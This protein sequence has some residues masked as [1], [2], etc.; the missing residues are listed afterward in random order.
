MPRIERATVVAICGIAF[1]LPLMAH[2]Y[3]GTASRYIGDDYC[4]GYIFRDHGLV[5]GQGWFYLN[6]GAVPTT[7]LLMAIT[8]PAGLWLTPLLPGL[9]LAV[10]VGAG[11]WS[12][13]R[14][15]GRFGRPWDVPS[16]LLLSELVV[17]VT[18]AGAPNVVQSLYLRIPL[19]EYVGPLIAL[20]LYAGFLAAG[21][22][23]PPSTG[24]LVVSGLA[25][26]VAGCLGPTY[27]VFQV[28]A[29]VLAWILTRWLA[30]P[31]SRPALERL[32]VAGLVGSI[33]ALAFIA[34][35]PGNAARQ[36][37][38]PP[39]PT[40]LGVAKWTLLASAFMF[41]RPLLH[42]LRDSIGALAPRL[43][44]TA[45]PWLPKGPCVGG[46]LPARGC[47]LPAS[48]IGR[49]RVLRQPCSWLSLC[50]PPWRRRKRQLARRWS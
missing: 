42:V 35:A 5:G 36:R 40:P 6:W 28:T 47:A 18:V 14:I 22:G 44:G 27:V 34:L 11:A 7:L 49:L 29:L 21:S 31:T 13:R 30:G 3:A 1:A 17:Y 2:A 23:R 15:T 33:A 39:P 10:W 46:A 4:A 25:A 9:A 16:S 45:P 32:L 19:F 8:E 48:A 38:F 41:V 50:S 37:H 20:T 26:F 12:I 43:L 24:R